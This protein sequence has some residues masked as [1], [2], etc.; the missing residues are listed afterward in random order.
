MTLKTKLVILAAAF[1]LTIVGFDLIAA[2]ALEIMR[3]GKEAG[4]DHIIN[5]LSKTDAAG[6]RPGVKG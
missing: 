3:V 6:H 4:Y 1:L 5:Y 2:P